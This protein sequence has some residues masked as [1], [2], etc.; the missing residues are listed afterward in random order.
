MKMKT[1]II[2]CGIAL[3]VLVV[4]FRH[5]QPN[6]HSEQSENGKPKEQA[7]QA[8][9]SIIDRIR[10]LFETSRQSL[11]E[12]TEPEFVEVLRL[13]DVI[14]YFKSLQLRKGHDIPFIANAKHS[15]VQSMLNASNEYPF[16]LV[17][18]TYN[19]DTDEIENYR[20]VQ[21]NEIDNEILSI[22]GE[23]P[24]VVLS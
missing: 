20:F 7:N 24:L 16:A 19:E 3:G 12:K 1:F 17:L 13:L 22:L 5:R 10:S 11:E 14:N 4:C 15:M 21:T 6:K 8:S 18:G 9:P 23:E 2:I